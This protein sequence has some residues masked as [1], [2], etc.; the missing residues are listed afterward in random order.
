MKSTTAVGTRLPPVK[1]VVSQSYQRAIESVLSDD[2]PGLQQLSELRRHRLACRVSVRPI[3]T[4]PLY[5]LRMYSYCTVC[6]RCRTKRASGVTRGVTAS[7]VHSA[8]VH[9]RWPV[10]VVS[11]HVRRLYS[12]TCTSTSSTSSILE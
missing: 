2:A 5:E 7:A 9:R 10:A 6:S 12:D 3:I 11:R 4:R 1:A 8:F